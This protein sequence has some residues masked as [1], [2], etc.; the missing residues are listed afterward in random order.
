MPASSA[1]PASDGASSTISRHKAGSASS[2]ATRNRP[3]GHS[4]PPT[5][6]LTGTRY[7]RPPV[8]SDRNRISAIVFSIALE[9][10]PTA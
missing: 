10:S 8:R 9:T 3:T 6:T 4:R 2:P 7:A 1:A 5:V